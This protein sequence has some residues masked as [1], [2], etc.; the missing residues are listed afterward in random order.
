MTPEQAEALIP[1]V[2]LSGMSRAQ[3]LAVQKYSVDGPFK[4]PVLRCDSCSNLVLLATLKEVGMCPHC[5]NTRV[6]NVRTMTEDD[7][8]KVMDWADKGLVDPEW[9]DLFVEQEVPL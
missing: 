2:D 7:V 8:K 5:S 6:K 1:K 9:M 3:A 4:E